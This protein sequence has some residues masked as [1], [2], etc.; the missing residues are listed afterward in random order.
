MKNIFSLIFLML[1]MG[2]MEG[3]SFIGGAD[4]LGNHKA[5]KHLDMQDYD[6][7]NT[8]NIETV[9][10]KTIIAKSYIDAQ[11]G[12]TNTVGS[13]IPFYGKNLTGVSGMGWNGINTIS[14]CQGATNNHIYGTGIGYYAYNNHN[15][16][17]GVGYY[18]YNNYSYGVGVGYYAYYN[19]N[20]GVGIGNYAYDNYNY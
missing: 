10:G 2:I 9:N 5:I 12:I 17:V 14:L 11:G 15:Y 7:T 20:Y 16:G 13:D 19:Y 4:N 1:L 6:I 18:A 3:A 8:G